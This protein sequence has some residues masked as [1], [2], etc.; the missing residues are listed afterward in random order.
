MKTIEDIRIPGAQK[1]TP[2][3]M[4]S[5]YFETGRH[6]PLVTPSGADPVARPRP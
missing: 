5:I 6:T 4:N 2:L 3:E 1:L